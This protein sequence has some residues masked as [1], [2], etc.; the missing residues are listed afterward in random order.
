M[1]AENRCGVCRGGFFRRKMVVITPVMV[2]VNFTEDRLKILQFLAM[3]VK[4]KVRVVKEE[5]K[6]KSLGEILEMTQKEWAQLE[7]MKKEMVQSE[8]HE[9]TEEDKN[10]APVTREAIIFCGFTHKAVHMLLEAIKRG[11]L[12][13]IPLKAMLTPYNVDWKIE[14]VLH[15]LE[16]EYE[17]FHGGKA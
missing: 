11:K 14:T 15:E 5:E 10:L 9:N 17:Y 13:H 4:A 6:K 2:A 7:Q 12:K 8:T 1:Y 16:K 3:T